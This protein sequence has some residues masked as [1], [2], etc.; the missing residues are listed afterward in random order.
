MEF[1]MV[2]KIGMI[3]LVLTTWVHSQMPTEKTVDS[4]IALA[5]E[6][7]ATPGLAVAVVSGD[8]IVYCKGFGLADINENRKVDTFTQFYLASS[9]KSFTALAAILGAEK[10]EW[11]LNKSIND[12]LN[13]PDSIRM[14]N[15]TMKDMLNHSS[16]IS[17]AG[18]F[19][20]RT[21]YSGQIDEKGLQ[22]AMDQFRPS[23]NGKIFSYSNV[24]YILSSMIM[25]KTT[26]KNWQEIVKKIVLDPAGMKNTVSSFKNVNKKNLAQ[27]YMMDSSGFQMLRYGK[28][29]LNM[30]AAGG[31]IS[32]VK[33]MARWLVIQ[34]NNGKIDGN[35]VFPASAIEESHK[36]QVIQNVK[37]GE[38][39]RFGWSLGWDMGEIQGDTLYHRYGTFPGFKPHVSYK[40]SRKIG[41]VVLVNESGAGGALA[42]MLAFALY[43][44]YSNKTIESHKIM[45]EKLKGQ[46]AKGR[47]RFADELR[48]RDE[49]IKPLNYS[50]ESFTGT[51][52]NAAAGMME[53]QIDG[54]R[55]VMNMGVIREYPEIY[56]ASKNQWRVT[57]TGSGEI[58]TF[59][60]KN[61]KTEAVEYGGNVFTRKEK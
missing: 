54:S 31:H 23:P 60:F 57:F 6:T 27:P 3:F 53:F 28:E 11:D 44:L 7:Q 48:K 50:L 9:T 16:G 33:D 13:I 49:R 58:L 52:V 42:D 32:S 24:G 17:N 5:M 2:N 35:Q 8:K 36:M 20:L 34:L 1:N 40:L 29:D 47:Q 30:H 4:L 26:K 22:N 61:E 55:L 15:I 18:S 43:D 56:D 59:I 41:V 45:F 39:R 46:I 12:I 19:N 38:V 51:F 37:F 14:L 21:A 25:E 10:K